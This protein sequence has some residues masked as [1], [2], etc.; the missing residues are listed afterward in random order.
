MFQ[1]YAAR[2]EIH[3][4]EDD[5]EEDPVELLSQATLLKTV[6][7]L[8]VASCAH[9]SL[10]LPLPRAADPSDHP[11]VL[12]NELMHTSGWLLKSAQASGGEVATRVI[13][14]DELPAMV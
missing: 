6:L 12:P 11:F 8:A 2:R 3:F 9:H 13:P 7:F 1:A 4:Q 14:V 10:A 5:M